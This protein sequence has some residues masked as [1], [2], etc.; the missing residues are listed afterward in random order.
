MSTVYISI[1]NSDDKLTQG[2]WASFV[3]GVRALVTVNAPKVWGYWLS[4]PDAP[5]QNMCICA[6]V[7]EGSA[8]ALKA[9]LTDLRHNYRQ[10]SVAWAEAVTEMI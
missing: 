10:D 2:E 4:S 3:T 8:A 6:E 1:G 5:W 9:Q 7:P